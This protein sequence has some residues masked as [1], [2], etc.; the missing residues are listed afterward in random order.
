MKF[1]KI[2]AG[3]MGAVMAASCVPMSVN[4]SL[5]TSISA[6]A[7]TSGTCGDNVNWVLSDDGVLT[8]SGT[9]DMSNY[10]DFEIS[11]PFHNNTDIKSV[12]IENGV[13]SI[14]EWAFSNCS[15]LT[16]IEIPDS[17]T[18]IGLY[19]FAGTKW[20]ENKQAEN[21]LVIVNGILIDGVTCT[22]D[23]VIPDT[24]TS[25]GEAAF[26]GC[27][28]L[29]SIE[30][31][32]PVTSIGTDAFSGTKWLE[33][34][35][36]ENPL[37]IVNGIL[38]DGKTCTG[39]VVIPDTVTSVGN[40]AFS[41]CSSL[42][43]IEIPNSVTSI[44]RGSFYYCYGLT[45][46]YYTGTS[47]DWNKIDIG[48]ENDKLISSKI[49]FETTRKDEPTEPTTT[50]TTTTT[51]TTTTTTTNKT[52]T[53]KTS[54]GDLNKDCKID[55][56]DAVLILKSYAEELASGKKTVSADFGDV[57]SDGK[58]DSKDAVWVLKY[59]AETLTGYMGSILDFIKK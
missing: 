15:S 8:I 19:A 52:S 17:V 12:I 51:I 9:G 4:S 5:I 46:V 53:E 47:D 50:T 55:S 6:S 29:T 33:N 1:K 3:V 32:D 30:I 20:L 25:I 21:P 27:S 44:G 48:K 23:V 40:C 14:G 35:Q 36:A 16:S 2:I 42:T 18:S 38:I 56:K 11:A 59:Y 34:K 39:G 13:T 26:P 57:N 45:D 7:E 10:N 31:P 24:V 49:H 37:V 54:L 43:S 41:E 58:V 28:S 22:G